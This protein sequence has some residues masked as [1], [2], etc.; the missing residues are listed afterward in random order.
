MLQG[1]D[2]ER[3][4]KARVPGAHT[5]MTLFGPRTGN[6][7]QDR[8]RGTLRD[9]LRTPVGCETVPMQWGLGDWKSSRMTSN[10]TKAPGLRGGKAAA[11]NQGEQPFHAATLSHP[12]CGSSKHSSPAPVQKEHTFKIQCL[13]SPSSSCPHG[14]SCFSESC[15]P[16]LAPRDSSEGALCSGTCTCP[17][18]FPITLGSVNFHAAPT[19]GG[20]H[21][22][23]WLCPP[24]IRA[25]SSHKHSGRLQARALAGHGGLIENVHSPAQAWLNHREADGGLQGREC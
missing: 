7:G 11:S 21:G 17:L 15:G 4:C 6:T 18:N 14:H 2:R 23:C 16:T 25:P 20:P 5:G 13:A 1:E 24:G 8:F 3:A 9:L 10:T 19:R 22:A 12:P